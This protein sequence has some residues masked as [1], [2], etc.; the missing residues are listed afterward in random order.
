VR[1]VLDEGIALGEPSASVKVQVDV[2]NLAVVAELLLDL[3]LLRF[4]VDGGD[5]Q[6]P[7]LDGSLWPGLQL[8]VVLVSHP[9]V[10]VDRLPG[11]TVAPKSASLAVLRLLLQAHNA[12]CFE[13]RVHRS[14]WEKNESMR[15]AG[16][17][18]SLR[19]LT[20]AVLVH[21]ELLCIVN[22]Q[23]IG[24]FICLLYEK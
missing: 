17:E 8:I 16:K 6:D 4:L 15:P 23:H 7:A 22:V 12:L 13:C 24:H 1:L 10:A 14:A 9:L 11:V 5:E 20:V 2:L 3:V 21:L 19:L 18:S